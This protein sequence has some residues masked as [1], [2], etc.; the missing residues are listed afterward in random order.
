[1][2]RPHVFACIAAVVVFVAIDAVWL[3]AIAGPMFRNALGAL[4]RAEPDLVAA[5]AFYLVYA[6]GMGALAIRPAL[7]AGSPLM[8]LSRGAVLGLTAYATF[9]LS[10]LAILQRWTW[11]LAAVDMAWDSIAT[12][13]ACWIGARNGLALGRA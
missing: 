13:L 10:N 5:A 8:A 4:L 2:P 6:I 1:M 7:V 3:V 9:D 11:A 12:A